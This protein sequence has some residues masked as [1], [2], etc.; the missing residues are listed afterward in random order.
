VDPSSTACVALLRDLART[1][2]AALDA[3]PMEWVV[4]IGARDPPAVGAY[5]YAHH[6]AGFFAELALAA[7]FG[8]CH[9]LLALAAL[10]ARVGVATLPPAQQAALAALLDAPAGNELSR[11]RNRAEAAVAHALAARTSVDDPPICAAHVGEA[12]VTAGDARIVY[13]GMQLLPAAQTA[14]HA[15]APAAEL[16]TRMR[17]RSNPVRRDVEPINNAYAFRQ[18]HQ[19]IAEHKLAVPFEVAVWLETLGTRGYTFYIQWMGRSYS[20]LQP[21]RTDPVWDLRVYPTATHWPLRAAYRATWDAGL[22]L[23]FRAQSKRTIGGPPHWLSLLVF[24][25]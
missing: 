3:F 14:L 23:G 20:P 15:I 19:A 22:A 4:A 7:T 1:G 13:D 18:L 8:T 2:D 6:L 24:P 17:A 12:V 21:G 11:P 9:D 25:G 16:E 5:V 10:A